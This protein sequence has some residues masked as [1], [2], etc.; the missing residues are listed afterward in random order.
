[1]IVITLIIIALSVLFTVNAGQFYI[2][3][4]NFFRTFLFVFSYA[5]GSTPAGISDDSTFTIGT[6]QQRFYFQFVN[7]LLRVFVL[8]FSLVMM[9]YFY[10]KAY[11]KYEN[12]QK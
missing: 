5:L 8:N 3:F 11:N 9:I 4:E 1:M 10:R 12:T 7:Y 6:I 2:E